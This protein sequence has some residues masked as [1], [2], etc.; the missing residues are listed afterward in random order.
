MDSLNAWVVA[1]GTPQ[2]Q[3]CQS[4]AIGS[5]SVTGNSS[6]TGGDAAGGGDSNHQQQ[7]MGGSTWQQNA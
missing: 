5:S 1:P 2:C 3:Q 7:P 4:A 6:S